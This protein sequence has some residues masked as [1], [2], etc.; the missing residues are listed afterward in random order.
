MPTLPLAVAV[1]AALPLAA[2]TI[3]AVAWRPFTPSQLPDTALTAVQT[4]LDPRAR[5]G[6]GHVTASAVPPAVAV[7]E[8]VVHRVLEPAAALLVTLMVYWTFPT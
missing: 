5:D 7:I 8:V 4:M 1:F 2:T 6:C 3:V